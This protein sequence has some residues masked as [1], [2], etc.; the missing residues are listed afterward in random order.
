MGLDHLVGAAGAEPERPRGVPD[1]VLPEAVDHR[2]L[3]HPEAA[4][5]GGAPRG[6]D[7]QPVQRAQQ[8]L[9]GI[10]VLRSDADPV[11]HAAVALQ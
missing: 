6:G 4:E 1:V 9:V 3:V 2:P 11:V 8:H 7:Q 5:L 10:D